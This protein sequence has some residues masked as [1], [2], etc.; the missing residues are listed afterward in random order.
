MQAKGKVLMR[1]KEKEWGECI[2]KTGS[3]IEMQRKTR[4]CTKGPLSGIRIREIRD[5]LWVEMKET[6]AIC[7]R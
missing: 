2:K 7:L 3:G 1:G 5:C 6:E 4:R